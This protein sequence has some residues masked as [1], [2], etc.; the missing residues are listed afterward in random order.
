MQ[1]KGCSCALVAF[2]SLTACGGGG[3]GGS[4]G[5]SSGVASGGSPPTVTTPATA[6]P[7]V[8]NA[9]NTAE[10]IGIAAAVGESMLQL[11]QFGVDVLRLV[12]DRGTINSSGSCRR[13]GSIVYTLVDPDGNR[14]PS[15]GDTLRAT[16]IVH[17]CRDCF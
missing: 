8:I 11:G 7:L 13:G 4:S 17:F 3:S 12:R 9:A 1:L 15:A 5:G 14:V 16:L 2:V 6:T 10:A